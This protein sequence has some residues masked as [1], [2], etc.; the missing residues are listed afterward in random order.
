[1]RRA[2]LADPAVPKNAVPKNARF[3]CHARA[4]RSLRALDLVFGSRQK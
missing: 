4:G 2:R 3:L 1:M